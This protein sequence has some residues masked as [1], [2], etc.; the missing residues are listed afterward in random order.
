MTN[1]YSLPPKAPAVH[2]L[3]M[4]RIAPAQATAFRV[5][6]RQRGLSCSSALAALVGKHARVRLPFN[7]RLRKAQGDSAR[8]TVALPDCKVPADAGS[9]LREDARLAGISLTEALRQ[10]VNRS[11]GSAH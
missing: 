5:L 8:F 4:V 9:A 11:L 10:L 2:R 7:P 1:L 6:A 3:P